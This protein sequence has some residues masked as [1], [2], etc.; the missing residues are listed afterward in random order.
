M[1]YQKSI[2]RSQDNQF[3]IV[4]SRTMCSVQQF[5]LY[6]SMEEVSTLCSV[7]SLDYAVQM[8]LGE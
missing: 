2:S 7:N 4:D 8:Y 1:K 5:V 3:G 6:I